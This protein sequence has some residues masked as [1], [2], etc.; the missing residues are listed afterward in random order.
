MEGYES[1]YTK[2]EGE[3]SPKSPDVGVEK[4]TDFFSQF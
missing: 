2:I 3:N 4:S 1:L